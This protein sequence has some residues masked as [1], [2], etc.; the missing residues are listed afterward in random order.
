[1]SNDMYDIVIVGGGPAGST[2]ARLIGS[3]Y[4]VLL[5]EKRS[6]EDMESP[7]CRKCCGGLVAPDAQ[8]MLAKFGLG[9]PKTVLLSPQLFAVRAIDISNSI[10]RFYQRNYINISREEFDRWLLSIAPPAVEIIYKAMYRSHEEREDGIRIKYYWSNQDGEVKAKLL[11]G[12]DGAFS[13]VRRQSFP[14]HPGP[15]LYVFIQE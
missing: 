15:Q 7:V 5:L 13:K 1:M 9:M 6:F 10:E 12:A 14:I 3:R 8:L 4:K 11:V 2:L